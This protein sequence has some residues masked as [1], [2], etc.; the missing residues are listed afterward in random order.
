MIHNCLNV[1][2]SERFLSPLRSVRNDDY[3]WW[4]RGRSCFLKA[5]WVL[6]RQT[7]APY[8][9]HRSLTFLKPS[10]NKLV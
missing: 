2:L 10:I 7:N 3:W 8:K 9:L 6:S 4:W 1:V 5:I